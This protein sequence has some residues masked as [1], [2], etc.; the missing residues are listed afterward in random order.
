SV[1]ATPLAARELNA[2]LPGARAT[3]DLS[4]ALSVEG[5]WNALALRARASA[6]DA[7]RLAA[8]ARIDAAAAPLRWDARLFFGRLDPGARVDGLPRAHANGPGRAR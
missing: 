2:I 1:T 8:A 7:G 4:A 6:G 3:A 5:P